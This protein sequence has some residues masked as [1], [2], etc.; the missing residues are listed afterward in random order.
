MLGRLVAEN[1]S[2]LGNRNNINSQGNEGKS[3][4]KATKQ[5]NST[6]KMVIGPLELPL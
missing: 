2:F 3:I 6:S 5:A 4:Q 1:L